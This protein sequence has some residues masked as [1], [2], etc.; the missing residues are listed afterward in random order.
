[1][2]IRSPQIDLKIKSWEK[3]AYEDDAQFG[4]YPTAFER[5]KRKCI[6]WQFVRFV[7]LSLK[8]KKTAAVNE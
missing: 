7:V 4:M 1:M 5:W 8:F 3:R 2:A 6:I